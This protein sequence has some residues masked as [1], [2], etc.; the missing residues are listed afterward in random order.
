MAEFSSGQGGGWDGWVLSSAVISSA[1]CM[2]SS[3][4]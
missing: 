2:R 3:T 1:A 4:V